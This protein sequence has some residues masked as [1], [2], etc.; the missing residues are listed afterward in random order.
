VFNYNIHCQLLWCIIPCLCGGVEL[1]AWFTVSVCLLLLWNSKGVESV[2]VK[3]II[4]ARL[5]VN[6]WKE[7]SC[8][9]L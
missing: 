6:V 5:I 2:F 8:K 1:C 4:I 7:D 3:Q 9:K